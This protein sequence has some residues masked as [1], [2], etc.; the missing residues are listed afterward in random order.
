MDILLVL[1]KKFC[2]TLKFKIGLKDDMI[3]TGKY[4]SDVKNNIS[5]GKEKEGPCSVVST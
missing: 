2:E 3:L 4:M 5:K 1:Q